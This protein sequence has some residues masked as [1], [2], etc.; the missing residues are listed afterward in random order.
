MREINNTKIIA[1]D[2]GYGNIKTANTVH[3]PVSLPMNQSR[4][5]PEIFWNITAF[6]TGLGKAT[7]N[8]YQTKPWTGTIIS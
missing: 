2:H 6:I 5:L 7:R 8:L 3:L 1:V 4:S